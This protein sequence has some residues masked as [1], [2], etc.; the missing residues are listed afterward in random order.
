M[1]YGSETIWQICT[2]NRGPP[3]NDIKPNRNKISCYSGDWCLRQGAP[4]ATAW[5]RRN[6][7]TG[8]SP[9]RRDISNESSTVVSGI[10]SAKS[11]QV[12]PWIGLHGQRFFY[13]RRYVQR[14]VLRCVCLSVHPLYR[15]SRT[16]RARDL[17][18]RLSSQCP[19]FLRIEFGYLQ[20]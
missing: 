2:V 12:P 13:T 9:E 18:Q 10:S 7:K 8:R 11:S 4:L 6:V 14:S 16:D 20:K 15:N 19:T 1:A 3:H 17:A 5:C